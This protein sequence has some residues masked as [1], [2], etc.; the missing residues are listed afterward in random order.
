MGAQI[1]VLSHECEPRLFPGNMGILWAYLPTPVLSYLSSQ[2]AL[3]IHHRSHVH[4]TTLLL[5]QDLPKARAG[6]LGLCSSSI[7]LVPGTKTTQIVINKSRCLFNTLP[8][9]VRKISCLHLGQPQHY[10]SPSRLDFLI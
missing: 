5:A 7:S 9:Q 4:V 10:L 6:P 8:E 3:G 2:R 1:A